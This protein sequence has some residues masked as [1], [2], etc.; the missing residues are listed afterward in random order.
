[1]YICLQAAERLNF[2]LKALM[3]SAGFTPGIRKSTS[4]IIELVSRTYTNTATQTGTETMLTDQHMNHAVDALLSIHSAGKTTSPDKDKSF[5]RFLGNSSLQNL[6]TDKTID[7]SINNYSSSLHQDGFGQQQM[8]G[9][10][11]SS[12]SEWPDINHLTSTTATEIPPPTTESFSNE[13]ILLWDAESLLN[14]VAFL[15]A[16]GSLPLQPFYSDFNS[17]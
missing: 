7:Q 15:E 16:F 5:D 13:E 12:T 14:N 17:S 2:G 4:A 1:M 3:R 9:L 6:S 10:H 8:D 11:Q